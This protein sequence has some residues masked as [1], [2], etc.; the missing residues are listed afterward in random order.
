MKEDPSWCSGFRRYG[1]SKL[2]Q[3]MMLYAVLFFLSV[4]AE[5]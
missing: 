2:C 4:G 3:L 1:A 5:C